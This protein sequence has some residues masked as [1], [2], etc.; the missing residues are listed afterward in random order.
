MEGERKQ[1]IRE[2]LQPFL[3]LLTCPT[4]PKG[5]ARS[6][7]VNKLSVPATLRPALPR[8]HLGRKKKRRGGAM[9][10]FVAL[11][12]SGP[13]L[14]P[15]SRP[16]LFLSPS[17]LQCL[18]LS[19]SHTLS[20]SLSPLVSLLLSGWPNE[21][22][23]RRSARVHAWVHYAPCSLE[24]GKTKQAIPPLSL[25]H[26]SAKCLLSRGW[27]GGRGGGAGRFR[28]QRGEKNIPDFAPPAP[29]WSIAFIKKIL[30]GTELNPL[31]R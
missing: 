22:E 7:G 9:G 23:G 29:P 20:L 8:M 31:C 17:L 12:S 26:I 4:P 16:S 3:I 27:D 18:S 14:A 19:V 25:M 30:G 6:A 2:N 1:P 15:S 13:S 21:A 24:L 28:G 11:K 5:R 10:L